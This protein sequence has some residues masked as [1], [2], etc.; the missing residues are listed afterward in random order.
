MN[1][2]YV[3][4]LAEEG[5]ISREEIESYRA[6]ITDFES[7]IERLARVFPSGSIGAYMHKF[8]RDYR[9]TAMRNY[10][11]QKI[12]K[13]KVDNSVAARMRPYDIGMQNDP[14]LKILNTFCLFCGGDTLIPSTS[15]KNFIAFSF[16]SK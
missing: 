13:P 12:T 11:V 1:T 3:Q 7:I 9:M 14:I 8:S 15:W 6:G 5:E 16:G 10:V 2:Q 4:E